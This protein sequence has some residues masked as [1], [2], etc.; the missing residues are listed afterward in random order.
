MMGSARTLL[1]VG[2]GRADKHMM[3]FRIWPVV[4]AQGLGFILLF[5]VLAGLAGLAH[6]WIAAT[7]LG[8]IAVTLMGR[9]WLECSRAVSGL[10]ESIKHVSP[11][12]VR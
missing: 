6:A 11:G 3:R 8:A 2:E 7:I 10:L 5:A 12:E 9:L 4:S 1:T